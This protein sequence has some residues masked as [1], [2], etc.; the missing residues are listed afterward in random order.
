MLYIKLAWRNIFRNKRRT[1][2][3][4]LAIGMGL[5]ALIFTD[6]FIIG[7]ER[8]MIYSATSTF[9]G[10]AQIFRVGYRETQ[11]SELTINN[12]KSIVENLQSEPIVDKF[13]S[14]VSVF[15]TVSAPANMAGVQIFGIEPET[16]RE[17]SILDEA[18]IEGEYFADDNMRNILIGKKLAEILE[19]GLG[20]RI[21]L[22]VSQAES[23]DLIQEL[24]KVSGIFDF[25]ERAMNSA[26]AFIR[27]EKARDMLAIGETAHIISIKFIN[28]ELSKNNRLPFWDK[29]SKNGNKAVSWTELFPQLVSIFEFAFVAKLFIS[30]ILMGVVVFVILNTLFMSLYERMFEFG[31]LR[32]IGTRPLGV[33]KLI[34][35]EAGALSVIS[36]VFGSVIV[37]IVNLILMKVGVDI[38][39][40]E[41]VGV[42]IR[43]K[44]YPVLRVSQ[45]T[46]NPLGV[47]LFTVIVGI[48]PALY[49]AKLNP[50]KAIR[51]SL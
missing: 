14:R 17:M 45:F 44:I 51:K 20:D 41:M 21:V 7:E 35:L 42:A 47:L 37:L 30:I 16:E 48:Y 4:G 38:T 19:V 2:I 36:I 29:Y 50:A 8:N 32:A 27:I 3:A 1:I 25:G 6:A 23:G 5:A 15:G 12:Y 43:E 26:A 11:E 28:P 9:A 34:L 33:A 40:T 10:E 46:I 49:A 22:T 24:F 39:G 18:I 13:T 31:I